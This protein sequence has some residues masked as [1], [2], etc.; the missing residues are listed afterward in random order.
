MYQ[1]FFELSHLVT[2]ADLNLKDFYIRCQFFDKRI[3][4]LIED[5]I[6]R[7]LGLAEDAP[8][9]PQHDAVLIAANPLSSSTRLKKLNIHS[10][11][12]RHGAFLTCLQALESLHVCGNELD[13]TQHKVLASLR[14]LKELSLNNPGFL[15]G[16]VEADD[17]DTATKTYI[18]QQATPLTIC[19][20]LRVLN[21][22]DG[23]GVDNLCLKR[24]KGLKRLEGLSILGPEIQSSKDESDWRKRGDVLLSDFPLKKLTI[25]SCDSFHSYAAF[26]HMRQLTHL[27]LTNLLCG[28]K[29]I[30]FQFFEELICLEHLDFSGTDIPLAGLWS[31]M[32]NLT[33]L[34]YLSLSMGEPQ[35]YNTQQQEACIKVLSQNRQLTKLGFTWHPIG[36]LTEEP[37]KNLYLEALTLE[38]CGL[39]DEALKAWPLLNCKKLDL[40]DNDLS[41]DSVVYIARALRQVHQPHLR[42]LNL[43]SSNLS[44]SWLDALKSMTFLDEICL[45]KSCFTAEQRQNFEQD[46]KQGNPRSKEV[47]W[48]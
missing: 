1:A 29:K 2:L 13:V 42:V 39:T 27:S 36:F 41:S 47:I 22:Q 31:S 8:F 28:G 5:K 17:P 26:Q 23:Y 40:S 24:L 14:N 34:R 44:E 46:F 7:Q 20:N 4:C 33:K 35:D 43:A 10:S 21:I 45:S 25:S 16:A 38:C 48:S 3:G 6:R 18:H 32:K 30:S 37:L 9:L 15:F 11:Q 12:F 19:P